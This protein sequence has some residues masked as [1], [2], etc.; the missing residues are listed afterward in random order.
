MLFIL[1]I[2]YIPDEVAPFDGIR[3]SNVLVRSSLAKDSHTFCEMRYTMV[4]Y[5]TVNQFCVL[6]RSPEFS[7]NTDVAEV[8]VGVH[9]G[10]DDLNG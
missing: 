3:Q 1:G 4:E 6:D 7:D 5:E 10:I 9:G 2:V 8:H